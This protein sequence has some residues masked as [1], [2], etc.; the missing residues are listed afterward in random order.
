MLSPEEAKKAAQKTAKKAKGAAKRATAG[1]HG[2]NASSA[3]PK[4]K[5]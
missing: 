5:K 1:Q 2:N 3:N 4:P